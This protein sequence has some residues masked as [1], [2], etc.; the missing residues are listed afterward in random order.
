LAQSEIMKNVIENNRLHM[1][2]CMGSIFEQMNDNQSGMSISTVDSLG[3][4]KPAQYA[5]K[6]AFSHILVV[7][8]REKNVINIYAISDAIKNLDAILLVRLI[9]FNGNDKYVRQIPVE[10]EANASGV[11]MSLKEFEILKNISKSQCC[12]VVQLNQATKTISQNILYFTDLKNLQ[13]TKSSI[14]LDINE[15]VKGYNIILKSPVLVKNLFIQTLS[16]ECL[17]SDNNFD[18]LPGRRTKVNVRYN[19][20]KAQ[21][22]K[23]I[24]IR[25]LVD[26][27]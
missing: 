7:P 1:A 20:T 22:L 15:A 9:D 11:L 19:G 18:L 10:I 2:Q 24:H 6:D 23:D 12:L 27:K 17:F 14:S 25:S 21:L 13:L 3:N 8:V 4:W 26:L 5:V 16:K